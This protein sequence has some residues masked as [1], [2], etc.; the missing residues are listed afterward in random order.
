MSDTSVALNLI[1]SDVGIGDDEIQNEETAFDEEGEDG[2]NVENDDVE[3]VRKPKAD[4][5]FAVLKQLEAFIGETSESF[6]ES[7]LTRLDELSRNLRKEMDN[8]SSYCDMSRSN[9]EFI[10]SP[11]KG[12]T[13]NITKKLAVGGKEC[14]KETA[15]ACLIEVQQKKLNQQLAALN[16]ELLKASKFTA[17]TE[18][19][20]LNAQKACEEA[21]AIANHLKAEMEEKK[22]LAAEQARLDELLKQQ[23]LERLL[24]EERRREEQERLEQMQMLAKQEEA[25]LWPTFP[26]HLP[27]LAE[28]DGGIGCL[29]KADPSLLYEGEILCEYIDIMKTRYEFYDDEELVSHVIRVY[30]PNFKCNDGVVALKP[31]MCLSIP[32]CMPRHQTNIRETAIKMMQHQC[33][34]W[35]E[36]KTSEQTFDSFKDV[37]FAQAQTNYLGTFLV[38]SRNKKAISRIKRKGGHVV[39]SLDSKIKITAPQDALIKP[40]KIVLQLQPLD[41]INLKQLKKTLILANSLLTASS[42]VKMSWVNKTFESPIS[43]TVILPPNPIVLKKMI[44][45]KNK[46]DDSSGAVK[47]NN[48][49]AENSMRVNPTMNKPEIAGTATANENEDSDPNQPMNKPIHWYMGIYDLETEDES[50]NVYLVRKKKDKW[51]VE[52]VNI[53]PTALLDV[54][55]IKLSEPIETFVLLR[56]TV[57]INAKG[58]EIIATHLDEMMSQKIVSFIVSQDRTTSTEFVASVIPIQKVE[59]FITSMEE[60]NYN[61]IYERDQNFLMKEGEKFRIT[62]R[63]NLKYVDDPSKL[64]SMF[65]VNFDCN[66]SLSLKEHDIFVQKC[67]DVY[68][69]FIQLSKISE[70]LPADEKTTSKILTNNESIFKVPSLPLKMLAEHMVTL[71]KNQDLLA[72]TVM[73][74]AELTYLDNECELKNSMLTRLALELGNEWIELGKFLGVSCT[75]LHTIENNAA[76]LKKTDLDKKIEMLNNWIKGLSRSANKKEILIQALLKVKRPDLIQ[77]FEARFEEQLVGASTHLSNP[78]SE[79][80]SSN[81]ILPL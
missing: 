55:T 62:F 68:R 64:V 73:T 9:L 40:E 4:D 14:C 44:R 53:E 5:I 26:L 32:H 70:Y 41:N 80:L 60:K 76:L 21:I 75:V 45:N 25:F 19:A 31:G 65:N 39:S 17:E 46:E 28:F 77:I 57:S 59:K 74:R 66:L 54:V 71:P 38:V 11:I 15:E 50:D 81:I 18:L 8:L 13:T 1:K 79:L 48:N 22:R 23:E 47:K 78:K 56:T 61:V 58:A 52:I 69:G 30:I 24:E 16:D 42:I 29:V 35:T 7:Q 72:L 33:V 43:M 20:S 10:R 36:L 67:Y 12:I 63:G 6:D 27:T 34:G 37:R 3:L 49:F 51:V 2:D